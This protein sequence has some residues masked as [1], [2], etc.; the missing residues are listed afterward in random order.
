[1]KRTGINK[2][3]KKINKIQK[4]TAR[5]ERRDQVTIILTGNKK[6]GNNKSFP[7]N[8]YFSVNGLN[9]PIKTH[10][11][12]EWTK[13]KIKLQL[14]SERTVKMKIKHQRPEFTCFPHSRDWVEIL[15][16]LGLF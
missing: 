2:K 3:K 7:I 16:L 12:A 1:M 14:L 5:K 8:N 10:R 15:S 11:V 13:K 9:S 4:K 6:S